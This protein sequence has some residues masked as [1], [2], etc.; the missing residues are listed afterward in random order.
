MTGQV[1]VLLCLA[2]LAIFG[3]V[4]K[5]L[6]ESGTPAVP[7]IQLP[8][9]SHN[10]LILRCPGGQRSGRVYW[11][12]T[13][14]SVLT[15]GKASTIAGPWAARYY[16]GPLKELKLRSRV[17]W[18]QLEIRPAWVGDS[19]LYVCKDGGRTLARYQVEVQDATRLHVSHAS[20]GQG[21]L[22][23]LTVPQLAQLF[24]SWGPW[25]ACD[26]CGA[27]GERKRLGYC[28]AR[29]V[30][31][32]AGLAVPCGLLGVELP[33][34][35]PELRVEVCQVNCPLLPRPA[36]P[37]TQTRLARPGQSTELACQGASIHVPVSWQRDG[38]PL[39]RLGLLRRRGNAAHSLDP[40][41]GGATYHIARV[42]ASDRGLYRC[43]V[44]GRQASAFRLD[45]PAVP[46]RRR[47]DMG[48]LLAV[49]RA[50]VATFAALFVSSAILE[51][52]GCSSDSTHHLCY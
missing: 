25:Q 17:H 12:Y 10:P 9:I 22:A 38:V 47:F 52:V 34:H 42:S 44:N 6:E 15:A 49:A 18:D 11:Q 5:L 48:R 50:L 30:S 37:P 32:P 1:P 24:T 28:Y 20:L 41:T 51:L 21:V 26:R 40:L 3:T 35:G 14:G 29:A 8:F 43:L 7:W 23:K 33:R 13:N 46:H 16:R 39:T 45:L 31:T 2:V 19:G 27:P 36:L 4:P